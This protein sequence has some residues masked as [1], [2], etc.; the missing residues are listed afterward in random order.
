[1]ELFENHI[2]QG[3]VSQGFAVAG[4]GFLSYWYNQLIKFEDEKKFGL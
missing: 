2:L 4:D 3:K 1:V